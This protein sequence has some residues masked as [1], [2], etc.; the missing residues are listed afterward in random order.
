V[1]SVISLCW[2]VMRTLLVAVL[3]LATLVGCSD[4]SPIFF[5]GVDT[6]GTDDGSTEVVEPD[7]TETDVV[8]PDVAEPDVVDPDVAEP[9]VVDPDVV[10]PDVVDPDVVDPDVVDP[11]VVDPDVVDPDVTT[12]ATVPDV[13]GPDVTTD[14][15]PDVTTDTAT[16][17]TPDVTTDTTA[18]TTPDVT[19]DATTDTTPDATPTGG[20]QGDLCNTRA[21]CGEVDA[22]A[23]GFECTAT[24]S[25]VEQCLEECDP[26]GANTCGTGLACASL[27]VGG[28]CY[29]LADTTCSVDRDCN[30]LGSASGAFVCDDGRCQVQSTERGLGESCDDD[31]EACEWNRCADGLLCSENTCVDPQ[32]IAEAGICDPAGDLT[33]VARSC[34]AD[35]TCVT[36]ADGEPW[37]LC[38][39]TCDGDIDCALDGYTCE[40]VLAGGASACAQTC[41]T[42]DE[43]TAVGHSCEPSGFCFP[44]D[45]IVG[46]TGGACNIEG[47]D[48]FD[49]PR[50]CAD[51][52]ACVGTGGG[53]GI[54]HDFC[55][56]ADGGSCPDAG[57]ACG[58]VIGDEVQGLCGDTCD[59]DVDC[60][61]DQT[62]LDGGADGFCLTQ[63]TGALAFGGICDLDSAATGCGPGVTC[64]R[65]AEGQPGICTLVCTSDFECGT[66]QG[67]PS[68]CLAVLA[69]SSV[70]SIDCSDDGICPAG[71]RCVS[72][73]LCLP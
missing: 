55:G 14:T 26:A 10:D 33:G 65:E 2:K 39:N 7:A 37:A 29:F 72:D 23:T 22:C 45:V 5:I 61:P 32:I 42:D 73:V 34:D 51:E 28:V 21:T 56:L 50:L 13:T 40:A 24:V 67:T 57:E 62:C 69:D 47:G 64:L 30:D 59:S 44:S 49:E 58:D 27:E 16:D 60:A 70:C 15:T 3:S 41:S 48:Y 35:A 12:D 17:T 4:D 6:V 66:I 38:M 46:E 18:D 54:C 52:R 63:V 25:G 20:T 43:C 1:I 71:L 68:E 31:E 8:D 9:D 11:D 19:P 53:Y 36:I